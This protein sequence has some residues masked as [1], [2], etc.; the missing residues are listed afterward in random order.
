[1]TGLN[2]PVNSM[3]LVVMAR[4]R[5]CWNQLA[6]CFALEYERGKIQLTKLPTPSLLRTGSYS[7]RPIFSHECEEPEI[8]SLWLSRVVMWFSIPNPKSDIVSNP[9]HNIYGTSV[10]FHI[11]EGH[12][13]HTPFPHVTRNAPTLTILG[14]SQLREVYP[15][16]SKDRRLIARKA[17]G[18]N[19]RSKNPSENMM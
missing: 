19:A 6:N 2:M 5:K 9:K 4:S 15:Q 14:P 11:V 10:S 17:L 7:Q 1:M 3:A 13:K 18:G 16:V 8:S 12:R